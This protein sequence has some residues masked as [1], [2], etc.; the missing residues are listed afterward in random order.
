MIHPALLFAAVLLSAYNH[1]QR[2]SPPAPSTA[3]SITS[4]PSRP[5]L[6]RLSA[7]PTPQVQS[8]GA[9]TASPAVAPA[10]EPAKEVPQEVKPIEAKKIQEK[11]KG[12]DL[13]MLAERL[14]QTSAIGVF[15]KLAINSEAA[16]LI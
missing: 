7:T 5:A 16:D 1:A 10:K 11:T 13:D 4:A 9:Q 8:A 14:K 12:F 15:T 6:P 3:I 2:A